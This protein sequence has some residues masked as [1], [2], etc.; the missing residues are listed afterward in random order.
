[1]GWKVVG[2]FCLEEQSDV[3]FKGTTLAAGFIIDSG[4]LRVKVGRR[5]QSRLQYS[6]RQTELVHSGGET[7]Q[8]QE[9]RERGV[10]LTPS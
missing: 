3:A 8:M 10:R 6:K 5:I 1:M 7:E 9:V 4:E 2:R